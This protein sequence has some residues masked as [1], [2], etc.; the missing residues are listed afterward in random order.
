[1]LS[2]NNS[3]SLKLP[4]GFS[5]ELGE[6]PP[7]E[8]LNRLLLK[9]YGESHPAKQLAKALNN[10]FCNASVKEDKT[11][12][13]FGF[14]RITSDQGLNA[15]LWDLVAEPGKFQKQ[16][17]TILVNRS[18][19]LIRRELPGCSVS[20]AAPSVAIEALRSQGFVLDPNGIRVMAYKIR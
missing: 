4:E 11:G 8:A 5:L 9:C 1:M 18:L 13:L 20:L 19:L 7:P 10:S 15:N 12:K 3:K 16:F 2:F 14:V 17:L 6:P